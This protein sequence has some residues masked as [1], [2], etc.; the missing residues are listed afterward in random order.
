MDDLFLGMAV[1]SA[2]FS[3]FQLVVLG[4]VDLD[5]TKWPFALYRIVTPS[6]VICFRQVSTTR[7]KN[8]LN[9][10]GGHCTALPLAVCH[11]NFIFQQFTVDL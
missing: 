2:N 3:S 5:P 4:L 9:R 11:T 8:R 7:L 1:S 6:P 10:I